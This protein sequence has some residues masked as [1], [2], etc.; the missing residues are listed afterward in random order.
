M[1]QTLI[2][3]RSNKRN[4]GKI[5][6]YFVLL[7]LVILQA[8]WFA[9]SVQMFTGIAEVMTE[10]SNHSVTDN[11]VQNIGTSLESVLSGDVDNVRLWQKGMAD[12]GYDGQVTISFTGYFDEFETVPV[13]LGNNTFYYGD[14][15]SNLSYSIISVSMQNFRKDF[16]KQCTDN[17]NYIAYVEYFAEDCQYKML[18]CESNHALHQLFRFDLFG[19]GSI[20]Y[21]FYCIYADANNR[22]DN[23]C[24]SS[25]DWLALEWEQEEDGNCSIKRTIVTDFLP[26]FAFIANDDFDDPVRIDT[27]SFILYCPT[28]FFGP[29]IIL[30][31]G[32]QTWD[33]IPEWL[34]MCLRVLNGVSLAALLCCLLTFVMFKELRNTHGKN[35]LSLVVAGLLSLFYT[36]GYI[37]LETDN[38]QLC[39]FLATLIY[40]FVL[41][42]NY[43][44]T[45][46]AIF[47]AWTLGRKGIHRVDEDSESRLFLLLSL[48][49]WCVPLLFSLLAVFLHIG[50]IK[51]YDIDEYCWI[52]D[53]WPNYLLAVQTAVPFLVDC[54]LFVLVLY[55]LRATRQELASLNSRG[56]SDW[57]NDR[58][59]T[60][61][62]AGI[63]GVFWLPSWIIYV[64]F[65]FKPITSLAIIAQ[66]LNQLSAFILPIVLCCN[67][68]VGGLWKTKLAPFRDLLITSF[69]PSSSD[70][71][72]NQS[73]PM[74]G[75]PCVHKN[76]ALI[77][78]KGILLHEI[79]A[80]K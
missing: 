66:L 44:W 4:M 52:V 43:W 17:N 50:G 23:S 69:S 63:F 53:G 45:A 78:S 19:R 39:V 68:R 22:M 62:I 64:A 21:S 15:T 70:S 29:P 2:R 41:V 11:F 76:G 24:P 61:K 35:V 36:S 27:L 49:G 77:D 54:F 72:N 20:L 9:S 8:A 38:P 10:E 5:P 55:R 42:P 80:K 67:K 40:Y 57:R 46:V 28:V 75:K 60:I 26:P 32:D 3:V 59:I 65:L 31:Y 74:Q 73:D 51:I 47:L 7:Y 34:Q 79:D 48:F 13:C 1:R 56:K 30:L 14:Q 71:H 58:Q 33:K 37:P 18:E 25:S 12:Y 6:G 16:D